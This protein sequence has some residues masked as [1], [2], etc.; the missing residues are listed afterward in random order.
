MNPGRSP[1]SQMPA[2][3]ELITCLQQAEAYSGMS[4]A[5]VEGQLNY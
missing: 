3:V 4:S 2:K 1:P 5:E